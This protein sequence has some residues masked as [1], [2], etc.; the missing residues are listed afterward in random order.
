MI[1][2]TAANNVVQLKTSSF[3]RLQVESTKIVAYK[4]FVVDAD[5]AA[6][7]GVGNNAPGSW[8]SPAGSDLRMQAGLGSSGNGGGILQIRSGNAKGT[9]ITGSPMIVAGGPGTG[10]GDGGDFLVKHAMAGASGSSVNTTWVD[11][12]KVDSQ[13]LTV[14]QPGG[15]AGTDEVQIYH[16]GTD[17]YIVPQSGRLRTT[18]TLYISETPQLYLQ[19]TTFQTATINFRDYS[20]IRSKA[21]FG[22]HSDFSILF[23]SPVNTTVMIVDR[24]SRVGIGIGAT[25]P[26]YLFELGGELAL[27][28][29]S[30]DPND[31]DEGKSVLW[32]SDG[33]G[34]GDDGDIMMKITAG[35]VTKTATLVDFKAV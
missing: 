11:V 24:T 21:G 25:K 18:G 34:S 28:E 19:A 35:G 9:D 13:G 29:L 12:V 14:L 31:P 20:A 6:I 22:S 23:E 3:V 15:V 4:D 2:G 16:N 33:T 7:I 27:N 26:D 10:A 1:I 32:Q 5:V 30:A 8:E 17:G